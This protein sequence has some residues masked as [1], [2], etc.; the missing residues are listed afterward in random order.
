MSLDDPT[1]YEVVARAPWHVQ[2]WLI[3]AE[4]DLYDL[5]PTAICGESIAAHVPLDTHGESIATLRQFSSEVTAGPHGS[6]TLD[7]I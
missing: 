7:S 1:Q 4:F 3:N 6:S 5:T 2:L